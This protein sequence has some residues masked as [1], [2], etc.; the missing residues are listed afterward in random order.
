MT[1][2]AKGIFM[3]RDIGGGTKDEPFTLYWQEY[4]KIYVYHSI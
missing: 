4:Q 1:N 3:K 2:A